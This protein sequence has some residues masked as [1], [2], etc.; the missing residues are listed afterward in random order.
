MALEIRE[1]VRV[2]A[3]PDYD[4]RARHGGSAI[5]SFPIGTRIVVRRNKEQI[6]DMQIEAVTFRLVHN[7]FAHFT[8]PKLV[9]QVMDNSVPV[10]AATVKEYLLLHDEGQYTANEMLEWLYQ[11]P[12]TRPFVEE[13]LQ[14]QFDLQRDD[15]DIDRQHQW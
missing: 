4:K 13:A 5:A 3:N 10:N 12:A 14:V 8:P 11:N 7:Q 15:E 9:Q 6:G 1:L 2:V